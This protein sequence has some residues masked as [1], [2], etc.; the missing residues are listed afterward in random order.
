M[1]VRVRGTGRKGKVGPASRGACSPE[2]QAEPAARRWIEAEAGRDEL[3]LVVRPPWNEEKSG[4]QHREGDC[5]GPVC[6]WAMRA[7][8]DRS[9]MSQASALVAGGELRGHGHLRD[10][11]ADNQ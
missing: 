7:C 3:L 4:K 5:T 6:G 1:Y 2:S 10:P 8:E 9:F 11:I